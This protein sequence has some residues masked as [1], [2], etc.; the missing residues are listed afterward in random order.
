LRTA[1]FAFHE[2][3]IFKK[4]VLY[5]IIL[6]DWQVAISYNSRVCL[7]GVIALKRE[8]PAWGMQDSTIL[9]SDWAI[10]A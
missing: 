4:C 1:R 3:L 7:R 8:N 10:D 9:M 6:S 5:R 2:R